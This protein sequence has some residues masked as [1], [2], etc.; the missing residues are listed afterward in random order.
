MQIHDRQ[1][2]TAG[3]FIFSDYTR[4]PH[5]LIDALH[6]QVSALLHALTK[7]F[8]I[9]FCIV[10]LNL[11][12]MVAFALGLFLPKF[13]LGRSL[14][15][16]WDAIYFFSLFFFC[17]RAFLLETAKRKGVSRF[18]PT[19]RNHLISLSPSMASAIKPAPD[20]GV[21]PEFIE[22]ILS[23]ESVIN[24][25]K[26]DL[27]R[28]SQ[29]GYKEVWRL[30]LITPDLDRYDPRPSQLTRREGVKKVVGDYNFRLNLDEQLPVT[31]TAVLYNPV[32]F[33]FQFNNLVITKLND[34]FPISGYTRATTHHLSTEI[35][36]GEFIDIRNIQMDIHSASAQ[37]RSWLLPRF[38]QE[39]GF[40]LKDTY[41]DGDPLTTER[42][43][44]IVIDKGQVKII[45]PK[46][47]IQRRLIDD[48]GNLVDIGLDENFGLRSMFEVKMRPAVSDLLFRYVSAYGYIP[49]LRYRS[50][51]FASEFMLPILDTP[52]SDS[53]WAELFINPSGKARLF[54]A[55]QKTLAEWYEMMKKLKQLFNR[56]LTGTD[57]HFLGLTKDYTHLNQYFAEKQEILADYYVIQNWSLF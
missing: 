56:A 47:F 28:T 14:P 20:N 19:K 37:N 29:I 11:V 50:F 33:N 35:E 15:F 57:Y 9:P 17:Y 38:L 40:P 44:T 7:I 46:Y 53:G 51:L 36:P 31:Q 43:G 10:Q 45:Y 49:V 16:T 22:K 34:R 55:K 30:G 12:M 26:A 8:L 2:E 5:N 52:V 18:G 41:V 13:I 4:R 48:N 54:I 24:A 23:Q 42:G 3:G 25:M 27:T 39:A 21:T 1:K 6:L 32:Y